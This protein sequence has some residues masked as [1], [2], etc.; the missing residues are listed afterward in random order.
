MFK[1]VHETPAAAALFFLHAPFTIFELH[2]Q[3]YGI[4]EKS[5]NAFPEE[6]NS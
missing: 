3:D 4:K 6:E 5:S 1:D 2:S